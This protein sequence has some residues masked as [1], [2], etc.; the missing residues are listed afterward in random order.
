[1]LFQTYMTKLSGKSQWGPMFVC[2]LFK[3]FKIFF[4]IQNRFVKTVFYINFVKTQYIWINVQSVI[5]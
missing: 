2:F 1:M 5:D 4:C 3:M